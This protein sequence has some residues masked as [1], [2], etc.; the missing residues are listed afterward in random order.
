MQVDL[1]LYAYDYSNDWLNPK[2]NKAVSYNKILKNTFVCWKFYHPR[3]LEKLKHQ[4]SNLWPS[5]LAL[6][7]DSS[8]VFQCACVI[9]HICGNNLQEKVCIHRNTIQKGPKVSLSWS[10]YIWRGEYS[11]SQ[12]QAFKIW[13]FIPT[14][15]WGKTK[16]K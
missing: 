1:S 15:P 5:F 12:I 3:I 2:R 13:R 9:A 11:N 8:P 7:F 4:S 14:S 16:G 10:I 6:F